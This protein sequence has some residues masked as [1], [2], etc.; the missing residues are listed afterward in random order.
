VALSGQ[1]NNVANP[2]FGKTGGA[3]SFGCS[4]LVCTLDFGNLFVG[5]GP[6]SGI[7]A[8]TNSALAPADDLIGA[9]DLAGLG[10]FMGAG[11]GPVN[12]VAGA[13]LGGLMLSF[14]ALTEG[15][16]TGSFVFSGAS[17]N[18]FQSDLARADITI[19]L[20]ANV[21]PTGTVPEPGTISIV[22]L[23][24]GLAFAARRRQAQRH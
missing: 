20:R 17:R 15:L 12:L 3:G 8:L 10:D 13:S 21:I 7:L 11:F 18:A 2:V 14:D 5:S 19:F 23:G 16:F 22:L 4:A 6:T 9:F 24:A 1:V